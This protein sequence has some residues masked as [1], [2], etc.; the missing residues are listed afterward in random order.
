MKKTVRQFLRERVAPHI[1]TPRPPLQ[2]LRRTEWC[3]EFERAMRN[4]LVMG[5]HRY[6]PM[7]EQKLFDVD[8]ATEA[9]RRLDRYLKTGSMEALVDA[10]N[11][12]QLEYRFNLIAG[13][14]LQSQDDGE[15]C[16]LPDEG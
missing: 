8:Y 14:R 12:C 9:K 2:V 10:A 7:A 6:R 5:S 16:Q 15:H 3:D 11:M 4:R 1:S 13:R